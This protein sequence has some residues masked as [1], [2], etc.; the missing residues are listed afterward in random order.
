MEPVKRLSRLNSTTAE[1]VASADRE[2]AHSGQQNTQL[3]HLA[4]Q[5]APQLAR[6]SATQVVST[7]GHAAPLIPLPGIQPKL[8]YASRRFHAWWEGYAFD[9][10]I[11][12]RAIM[13]HRVKSG[14]H[15]TTLADQADLVAEAIWGHNR[16]E[17]GT[18]AWTLHLARSLMID[19]RAKVAVFGAGRGGPLQDLK[20]GTRWNIQGYGRRASSEGRLA[21][22]EYG[23]IRQKINKPTMGGGM[24]IFEG[25]REP[26]ATAL[27]KLMFEMLVPGAKAVIVDFTVP[28]RE[29]RLKS[30]FTAPWQGS[31]RPA[32]EVSTALTEAGFTLTGE[33]DET[34][35]YLPLIAHGWAGWRSAWQILNAIEDNRQRA[36]LLN[37]MSTHANIWAERYEALQAGYLQ[38]TRFLMEKPRLY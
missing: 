15:L 34:A 35:I 24:I 10:V 3:P 23:R 20:A 27:Y 29:V 38:V 6:Q 4:P 32:H 31:P 1:A 22:N 30:A 12:R 21:V 14:R 2:Y 7:S 28:R 16:L 11:E 25:H 8:A 26:D 17:P 33:I 5:S 37:L 9:P 13:L 19:T 18:P 36:A